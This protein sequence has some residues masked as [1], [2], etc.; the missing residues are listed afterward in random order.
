MQFFLNGINK[1]LQKKIALEVSK[2]LADAPFYTPRMPKTNTPFRIKISSAG[3][4]GWNSDISGY[5]YI[6]KHPK[7]G[8]SW[9]KIPK[10]FFK[11]WKKFTHLEEFPNSCL[12]NL[13]DKN[14]ATLGLHQDKEENNFSF[15]VLSISLGNSAIFNYGR[16][17]NHSTLKKICLISG[18][19]VL[20]KGESR[21]FYHSISKIISAEKNVLNKKKISNIPLDSRICITLRKFFPK[22]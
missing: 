18:S 12:I 17:K 11:I 10:I 15:P 6:K 21:L 16:S 4:W 1:V 14:N 19:I 13:Y 7:T 5:N 3:I 8:V 20:M 22:G 9:P 2:I